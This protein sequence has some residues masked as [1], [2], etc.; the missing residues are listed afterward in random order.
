MQA[1]GRP[2]DQQ[3]EAGVN[4]QGIVAEWHRDGCVPGKGLA[5]SLGAST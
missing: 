3:L 5:E 4:Q 1:G 2:P